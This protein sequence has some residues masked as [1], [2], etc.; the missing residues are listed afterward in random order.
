MYESINYKPIP[1]DVSSPLKQFSKSTME[2][3][4]ELAPEIA[5]GRF[6]T[7][8]KSLLR[9]YDIFKSSEDHRFTALSSEIMTPESTDLTLVKYG[10]PLDKNVEC[11]FSGKCIAMTLPMFA[12][13]L[14]ELEKQEF[15]IHPFVK[16][17]M[18]EEILKEKKK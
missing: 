13:I 9:V 3:L 14:I 11:W 2:T 6:T 16:D 8:S 15:P 5:A 12:R 18:K 1:P 4:T 17:A 7:S 10:N